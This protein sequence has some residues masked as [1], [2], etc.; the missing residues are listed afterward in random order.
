VTNGEIHQGVPGLL[1]PNIAPADL[2]SMM[3]HGPIMT[4][5]NFTGDA[6]FEGISSCF[7]E[8]VDHFKFI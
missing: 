2:W 1:L 6:S 3:Q 8:A 7:W 4:H 5:R